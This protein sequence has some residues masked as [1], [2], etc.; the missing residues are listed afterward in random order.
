MSRRSKQVSRREFLARGLALAAGSHL[1]RWAAAAGSEAGASANVRMQSGLPSITA[2]NAA[3]YR[4]VHQVL[5]TPRVLD[6]PLAL[7]ILGRDALGTLQYIA[8]GQSRAMRAAIAVR[9][10]FAEDRLA[11]A[12]ERGVRQYVVLGAGLDTFAYRNPHA[13]AGL[14]VFEVDHPA[15][16][17]WKRSRLQE[18]GIA[19]TDESVFVPVDFETD[20]LAERLRSAGLNPN[21]PAFFSLLG[22]VI[23]ISRPALA[24]TIAVVRSFAPGSEIAFEFSLPTEMLSERERESREQSLV[25]MQALGEPWVSFYDPGSLTADL[26]AMGFSAVD[27]LAPATANRR[28]FAGRADRLRIAGSMHLL[29]A[30]V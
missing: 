28:Y 12:V 19:V 21:A 11:A 14:R 16:Q 26:G 8:D 22:V 20:S 3:A 2:Q 9:S 5:D 29:A 18:A 24:A 25:R 6:D 4:A 13:Q 7:P 30:R 23:Y 17:R 27:V 10:R 15:T 1:T